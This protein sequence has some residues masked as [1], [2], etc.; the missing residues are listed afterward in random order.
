MLYGNNQYG[1]DILCFPI[2]KNVLMWNKQKK[3]LF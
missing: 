2:A 1:S 3:T